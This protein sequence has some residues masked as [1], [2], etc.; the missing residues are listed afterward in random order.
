MRRAF[1]LIELLVVVT[2][3]VVLLAL[4]SPALDKA[5]YAA[6]KLACLTNQRN[7]VQSCH[8]YAGD[9]Q[10][11]YPSW[12]A[13]DHL[14]EAYTLRDFITAESGF[15]ATAH[16]TRHPLGIGSLVARGYLPT[17]KLGKI[18]HCP[19]LNN[20]GN[21]NIYFGFKGAGCGMDV[22]HDFGVGASYWTDPTTASARVIVSYNYRSASWELTGK[23][24]LS[25]NNTGPRDVIS[26]DMPD[27][28]FAGPYY[29]H[30]DGYNRVFADGHGGFYTN[31]REIYAQVGPNNNM[32]GSARP[33]NDEVVYQLLSSD[34][35]GADPPAVQ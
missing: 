29:A 25:F 9:N 31:W 24:R 7:I 32:S 23:N 3:I 10:R 5:I 6:E 34:P 14:S 22:L 2:V 16:G 12:R 18:L 1:T 4:L 27:N 21:P 30:P 17:T 13:G 28:R 35:I 33:A 15:R 8:L 11:L 26:V 20:M 19:N